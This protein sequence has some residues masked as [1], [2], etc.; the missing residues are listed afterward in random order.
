MTM[1]SRCVRDDLV[2][3]FAGKRF[4]CP[5]G[6]DDRRS[7]RSILSPQELLPAAGECA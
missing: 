5:F 2:N 3:A 7:R 6:R 4:P 1:T